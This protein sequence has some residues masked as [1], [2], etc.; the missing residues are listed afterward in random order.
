MEHPYNPHPTSPSAPPRAPSPTI[1]KNLSSSMEDPLIARG[2]KL[3]EKKHVPAP[4]QEQKSASVSEYVARA[5]DE[6]ALDHVLSSSTLSQI[7]KDET[8]TFRANLAAGLPTEFRTI[9][10]RDRLSKVLK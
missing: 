9:S 10:L 4:H 8:D 6:V 5:M 1:P 3:L 2:K 7:K